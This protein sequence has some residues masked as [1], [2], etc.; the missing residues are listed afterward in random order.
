[1]YDRIKTNVFSKY[2]AIERL[3]L[4]KFDITKSQLEILLYLGLSTSNGE[5]SERNIKS[6]LKLPKSTTSVG[7][8]GLV[9]KGLATKVEESASRNVYV[10]LTNKGEEMYGSIKEIIG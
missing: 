7:I 3:M 5:I 10:A 2:L 8:S 4:N 1:M 9:E 6:R